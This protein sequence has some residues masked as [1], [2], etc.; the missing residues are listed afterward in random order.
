MESVYCR[1][2]ISLSFVFSS[3]FLMGDQITIIGCG[4]V[5]LTMA[6]FLSGGDSK[7]ICFD[8]DENKILALNNKQN[9]I[10]EP[11]LNELLFNEGLGS[12]LTFTNNIVDSMSSDIFFICVPTPADA[13]GDCDVRYIFK[14]FDAILNVEPSGRSKIICV[15]SAVSPG[16]LKRLRDRLNEASRDDV[17][18]VYNPEFMREGSAINDIW[19]KN[20]IVLASDSIAAVEFIESIY[21]QIFPVDHPINYIKTN[22]ETAEMIKYAWNSFSAIRLAY[23]NELA[24]LSRKLGA[25]VYT[26]IKGLALS[27]ELLPTDC[28]VPGP[29]YG[30]S[31]LSKDTVS[32]SKFIEHNGFYD[33]MVHQAIRSN[34]K[35]INQLIEDICWLLGGQISNKK[36]AI[37]GLSFKAHTNDIRNAPALKIIEVLLQKG[38]FLTAYDP[39]A[40][41]EMKKIYPR[42]AYYDCPYEAVRGA[43]C[44]VV[45]TEWGGIK[46]LDLSQVADLC[47]TK[48]IFDA[49]NLFEIEVLKKYGYRFINMGKI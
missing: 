34:K 1:I 31:C 21:R 48:N 29:G 27:E 37:L 9:L 10:Y 44:V 4:Y 5:G 28:L 12:H 26:V 18:L 15:K 16:T 14:A 38:F 24:L 11:G 19:Y 22:F 17:C 25:N 40:A 47:R 41:D 36:V 33:S 43:D 35:H 13:L 23:V 46:N 39:K 30:G 2:L 7:V 6:A 49:R 42:V 45:L 20:P 32:F 3:S 8:I